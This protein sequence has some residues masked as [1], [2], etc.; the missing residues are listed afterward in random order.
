MTQGAAKAK[1]Q[2]RA[3]EARGFRW[4]SALAD[5]LAEYE[6]DRK[7]YPDLDA[8][9][10]RLIAFFVAEAASHEAS[11]ENSPEV[12]SIEPGN[13]ATDVDP[14]AS[15]IKVTFDRPMKNLS[16]S[17]LGD[18]PQFPTANGEPSYDRERKVFSLPVKLEPGK[19]Y[20]F[21]LNGPSNYGFQ[22]EDGVPL[23]PIVVSFTTRSS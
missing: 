20:H 2:A 23:P 17:V 8:F 12:V 1:E 18:G 6:R 7:T 4:T 13:G 19:T 22:S 15:V 9:A 21:G 11:E 10:P 14:S 3:E 5:L 16:W